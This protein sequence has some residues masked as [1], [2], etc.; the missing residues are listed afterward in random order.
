M[1][2]IYI[3]TAALAGCAA[4]TVIG[5]WLANRRFKQLVTKVDNMS[6]VQVDRH[7]QL[8]VWVPSDDQRA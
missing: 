7:L 5:P 4:Y 1:L 2:A 3:A 8:H 6:D